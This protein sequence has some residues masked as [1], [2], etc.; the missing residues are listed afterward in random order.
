MRLPVALLL[1]F[2]VFSSDTIAGSG[3]SGEGVFISQRADAGGAATSFTLSSFNSLGLTIHFRVDD[4]SEWCCAYGIRSS[5]GDSSLVC[6]VIYRAEVSDLDKRTIGYR[7]EIN[8]GKSATLSFRTIDGASTT[9]SVD[10]E[11]GSK[12]PIEF[13]VKLNEAEPTNH[14]MAKGNIFLV[15]KDGEATT[16][17]QYSMTPDSESEK[18]ILRLAKRV[19]ERNI[20][21]EKAEP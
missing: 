12:G 18:D 8:D 1:A 7:Y 6:L 10:S 11:F 21:T 15:S 17:K 13:V 4:S 5:A 14:G 20:N 16:L 9:A 19:I 2:A 3:S